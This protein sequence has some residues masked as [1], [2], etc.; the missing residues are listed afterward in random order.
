M[1]D[2]NRGPWTIGTSGQ[3]IG[4]NG[5]TVA[6]ML[7][8]RPLTDGNAHLI[9]AAPDMYRALRELLEDSEAAYLDKDKT[10]AAY[11]ALAKA[12]GRG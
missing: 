9:S 3:I 8:D 12:E 11:A 2:F 1:S 5:N 4:S 6:L 7:D 10:D